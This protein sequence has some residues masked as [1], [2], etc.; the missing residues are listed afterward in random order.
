MAT[1]DQNG[2]IEVVNDLAGK[3][4]HCMA[5]EFERAA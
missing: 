1:R 3:T 4:L 5:I 2:W